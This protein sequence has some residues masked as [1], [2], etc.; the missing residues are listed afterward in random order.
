MVLPINIYI[1][2][3]THARE[4]SYSHF[5]EILNDKRAILF[6]SVSLRLKT[7]LTK[8]IR[9][10]EFKWP[11][12]TQETKNSYR[13]VDKTFQGKAAIASGESCYC[14]RE[15]LLL[16]QR[17]AATASGKSC[18]C[19]REKLVLLQRK[20]GAASGKNWCCFREKLVLLQGHHFV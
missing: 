18:Y 3:N 17:K 19:F 6:C 2:Y 1:I 13:M 14:F 20:A 9:N 5:S 11:K 10:E 12:H 4:F 8:N 7:W 15:K 16:L